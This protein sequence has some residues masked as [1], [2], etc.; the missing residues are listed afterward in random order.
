DDLISGDAGA[1]E[2]NGGDGFDTASYQTAYAGVTVDLAAGTGSAGDAAGDQLISIEAVIGSRYDDVIS[3]LDDPLKSDNLSGAEGNDQLVGRAASDVLS[4]D[5]GDD[6][7]VGGSGADSLF[8]G[9]GHDVLRGGAGNDLLVGG[10]GQDVLT[11]GTGKDIFRF[12][13]LMEMGKGAAG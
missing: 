5:D 10:V 12:Y 6:L 7:L 1:D 3:G 11:G 13:S 2:V 9:N 4:G 8:G